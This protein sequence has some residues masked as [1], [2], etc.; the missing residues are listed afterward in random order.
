MGWTGESWLFTGLLEGPIPSTLTT[1][2]YVLATL[3]FI[4]AGIGTLT[5][6]AW[7]RP[8]LIGAAIFSA[9]LMVIFWDGK[10]TMVV[11]KGLVGLTINVALLVVSL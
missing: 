6:G 7:A 10:P 11:E 2:L 1:V 8:V 9:T 3:A 4:I 5:G